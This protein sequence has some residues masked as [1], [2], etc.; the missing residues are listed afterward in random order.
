ME[1]ILRDSKGRQLK[2]GMVVSLKKI[3]RDFTHSLPILE[4]IKL[5]NNKLW[6]VYGQDGYG[7]VELWLVKS[8]NKSQHWISI[9]PQMTTIVSKKVFT[10]YR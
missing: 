1:K 10:Q 5:R 4:K 9:P 7:Y 3:P 2:A 6:E 8:R